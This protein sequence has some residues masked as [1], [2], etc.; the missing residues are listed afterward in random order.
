MFRKDYIMR[1]YEEFGKFLAIVLGFKAD[2]KFAELEELI[3]TS[4][5]KYTNIEVEIAEKLPNKDF[6]QLLTENYELKEANLK[7]LG[8]L[9]YEKGIG[10]SKQL[11]E[12]E[13]ENAFQ[14]TLLIFEFIKETSLE[15]DFSLDMHF[16]MNSLKQMLNK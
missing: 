2:S 14:K 11:K 7:M 3:N 9:L 1:Q 12:K 5:F 15:S 4:A 8:D 16:K 6:I 13:A 10:Y